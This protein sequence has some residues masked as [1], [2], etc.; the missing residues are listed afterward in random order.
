MTASI[1]RS[2]GVPC[3]SEIL[4]GRTVYLAVPTHRRSRH[5]HA[6]RHRL[7]EDAAGSPRNAVHERPQG[8]RLH[9][10]SPIVAGIEPAIEETVEERL[11]FEE[12]MR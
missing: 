7:R 2:D 3:P 1:D 10:R 6:E 4:R 5:R 12:A 11:V 8:M 9:P